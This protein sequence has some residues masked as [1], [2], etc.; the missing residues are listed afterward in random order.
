ML[1][2]CCL[3]FPLLFVSIICSI[4]VFTI[5]LQHK[6]HM[7]AF[8]NKTSTSNAIITQCVNLFPF[9]LTIQDVKTSKYVENSKVNYSVSKTIVNIQIKSIF[10]MLVWLYEQCYNL[11]NTI[12]KEEFVKTQK[13]L[14][15]L[16]FSKFNH[17]LIRN[18]T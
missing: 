2:L 15:Q 11:Q 12:R 1:R 8:N 17:A 5:S 7:I 9:I 6:V 4:G 18:S 16:T 13:V 10:S 14:L 3:F